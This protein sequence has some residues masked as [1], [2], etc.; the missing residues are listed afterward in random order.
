MKP[1]I[2]RFNYFHQT[3]A[4][5]KYKWTHSTPCVNKEHIAD[6]NQ[7][8]LPNANNGGQESH[9]ILLQTTAQNRRRSQIH[10]QTS[11][12]EIRN[13]YIDE[14]CWHACPKQLIRYVISLGIR[15]CDSVWKHGHRSTS[16]HGPGDQAG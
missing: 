9:H 15:F 5:C 4:P 3:C 13:V 16:S 8:L 2:Q 6:S 11:R 1:M 12:L 14:L 10:S 7:A